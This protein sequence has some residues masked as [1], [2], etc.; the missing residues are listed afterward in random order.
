MVEDVGLKTIFFVQCLYSSQII[1][2]NVVPNVSGFPN[3]ISTHFV[4][5]QFLPLP[6][7]DTQLIVLLN[8]W[9]FFEPI[10]L[11]SLVNWMIYTFFNFFSYHLVTLSSH[12][13]PNILTIYVSMYGLEKD[14]L[15]RFCLLYKHCR[16]S[17]LKS[18]C[19]KTVS[20]W[21]PNSV[22]PGWKDHNDHNKNSVCRAICL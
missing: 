18:W 20:L 22:P 14:Y 21:A 3:N 11:V 10:E 4:A 17:I 15:V 9:K 6:P 16:I 13:T 19:C 5:T 2:C 12:Y 1:Y 8:P 7:L